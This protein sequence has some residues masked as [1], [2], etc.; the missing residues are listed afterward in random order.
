MQV[1]LLQLQVA[2]CIIKPVW[3]VTRN[4]DIY[5]KQNLENQ[6]DYRKVAF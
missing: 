6:A 5:F 1:K 4:F 2:D 3:I